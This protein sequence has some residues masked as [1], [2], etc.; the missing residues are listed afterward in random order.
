M[1][2]GHIAEEEETKI[3]LWEEKEEIEKKTP[4]CLSAPGGIF[5]SWPVQVLS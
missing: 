3:F 2:R 4:G 5:I 1:V